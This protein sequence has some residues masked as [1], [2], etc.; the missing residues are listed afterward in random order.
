MFENYIP[1]L[2]QIVIAGG[3][4]VV[5][6]I[7]SALL[8]KSA[9]RNTIKDS[10]Y[11]CGMLPVGDSQPRF[12]VKFYIVAMLFVLFDIEVVFLY[13]WAIIYKDY[14]AAVGGGA[15]I[16]AVAAGFASILLV[17][18]GYAWK[19]GVLDWKS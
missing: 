16:L 2:L 6:L 11:E 7:A 9:K 18:F 5:T 8:G 3:F 10:A 14:L 19:K 4:A 15:S 1:V 12:S 13:P 17:A